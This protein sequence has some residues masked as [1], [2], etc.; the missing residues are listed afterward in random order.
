MKKIFLLVTLFFVLSTLTY[1]LL[2]YEKNI[3]INQYLEVQKQQH[4]RNYQAL[5]N[6]Y[7]TLSDLIFNTK[8]NTQEVVNIFKNASL[9]NEDDKNKARDELYNHLKNTYNFLKKYN[10]KQL[11][12]HTP[13]NDSFLRFHRPN[14]YGDNLTQIRPTVKYANENI[15][16]IDGFE[17]GRIYNGYRFVFPMFYKGT[18]IGSVEISFSTLA[19]NL[20]FMRNYNLLSNFIVLKSVVEE[21]LFK[22]E[23]NNYIDSYIDGFY[24]EEKMYSQICDKQKLPSPSTIKI[25]NQKAKNKSSF[26]IYDSVNNEILTFLKIKNSITDNLV[27]IFI[28]RNADHYILNK[29]KNFYMILIL[30]NLFIA[31]SLFFIYKEMVHR[32]KTEDINKK[33][34]DKIKEKT[35][36]QSLLLSLFDKGDTVLFKC[37]NDS[38]WS[39]EYVSSSV[40]SLT[41]YNVEDFESNAIDY[42]SII[43]ENDLANVQNEVS[44]ALASGIDFFKLKPY[45]IVTKQGGIKWVMD[46]TLIIKNNNNVPIGFIGTISDIS[47]IKNQERLIIQQSRL[48]Q[49][50]EMLS[51]IAHQWRQPL[52]AISATLIDLKLQS[53]L[54]SYNLEDTEEAKEYQTYVNERI[55]NINEFVQSLSHTID[56]FRNFFKP[57]KKIDHVF[58][59]KPLTKALDIIKPS[60][61]ADKIEIIQE[62]SIC[63][64][65]ASIYSNELMQ[66]I[67]SILKNSQ[68]NFKDKKIENPKIFISCKCATDK[69]K[70]VLQISDNGG[71]I[72]NN[73][74]NKIF[75]P[76]F[77]TKT[78]KNGTGLGLYMSKIIIEEHHKG[79]LYVENTDIGA[80]FSIELVIS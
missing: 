76:Y 42:A 30:V 59:T 58:F 26:S 5:Y 80:C 23:R 36:E 65:K 64:K 49:M 27:G 63:N 21:K 13:N 52:S 38:M 40:T 60:L 61:E 46:Y 25:L 68:D 19:F 16:S 47:E 31:L 24:F 2:S 34:E 44:L 41:G 75:D 11:H 4:S 50:G 43:H 17:E 54:E 45:R 53:E 74:I 51:M 79:K 62:C 33:L 9:G 57:D 20:D 12:F 3:K 71:G 55:E 7:K 70:V 66:V 78:E 35:K 32:S 73:I 69:N 8:I 22:N 37:N 14:L 28:V 48:A 10:I 6:E 39:I 18:H 29:T 15:K 72:Q 56:D 67:L 77:S 1:I